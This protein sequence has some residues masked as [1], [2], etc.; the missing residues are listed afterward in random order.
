MPTRDLNLFSVGVLPAGSPR[1]TPRRV[2]C[3]Q[4]IAEIRIRWCKE[5]KDLDRF[6]PPERNT[7]RHVWWFVFPQVLFDVFGGVSAR[8]YMIWGSRVTWKS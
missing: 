5:H 2:V 1:Y 6:R 4:G 7:L 3:R 8:P